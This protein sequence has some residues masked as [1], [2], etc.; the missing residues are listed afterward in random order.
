MIGDIL[1]QERERQQ[2]TVKDIERGTSI[3]GLYIEAIENGEYATLPGDVYTKGF[4]RNY[5]NFL[6]LDADDCVR[7]YIAEN[8]PEQAAAMA[9]AEAAEEERRQQ[10]APLGTEGVRQDFR[11]KKSGGMKKNSS[12]G[13]GMVAA[14]LAL[15]VLLGGGAYLMMGG[16]DDV[17]SDQVKAPVKQERSAK[18]PAAVKKNSP[19]AEP[20]ATAPAAAPAKTTTAPAQATPAAQ[21][22]MAAASPRQ[23]EVQVTATYTGRCWT[24]V[25]AD[26][27]TVFEGTAEQGKNMSWKGKERVTITAGNAGAVEFTYNGKS[28]GKAGENGQVVERVFTK[29]TVN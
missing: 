12:N 9:A 21:T 16:N 18:E 17:A 11:S 25:V 15:L 24:R 5:A 22:P 27:Q 7:R 14:A 23:E 13:G 20:P 19:A 10:E 4:I 28:L 6:R 1:R 3:R 29:D 2:L 26:G 8:H